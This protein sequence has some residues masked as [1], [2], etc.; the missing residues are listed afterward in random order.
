MT[1]SFMQPERAI[2]MDT[3]KEYGDVIVIGDSASGAGGGV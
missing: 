3:E 1:N 2:P